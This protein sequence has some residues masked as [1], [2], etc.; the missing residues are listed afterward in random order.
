VGGWESIEV[1]AERSAVRVP[2][3]VELD[4]GATAKALCVDRAARA[5]GAET[6]TAALVSIGGD[7]AL[8]G[9]ERAGGWSVVV[10]D[11]HAT[12]PDG[13][14]QRVR[15]ASGGLATSGTTVRRWRRGDADLHHIVDPATGCSAD[16]PWRTVSVAAA[17]C[18]DANIATTAA[19]VMGD[20]APGWLT[21]RGLPARLVAHDGSVTF[22]GGWPAEAGTHP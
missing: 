11:D 5:V 19:I 6:G 10:A 15:I 9:P 17:S 12:S 21:D 7:L 20:R 16:S 4:F 3:G 13:G 8:G 18:V 1:D 2:A 22:V 14:G